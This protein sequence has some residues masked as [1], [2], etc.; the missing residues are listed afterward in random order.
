MSCN[1]C[2]VCPD[3]EAAQ[4]NIPIGPSGPL[5][6][7]GPTGPDGAVGATGAQGIQGIQGLQGDPGPP[8]PSSGAAPLDLY[9][10][11]LSNYPARLLYMNLFS[12]PGLI[13]MFSITSANFSVGGEGLDLTGV[14]GLDMRGWCICDGSVYVRTDGTGNIISPNLEGKFIVGVDPGDVDFSLANTGGSKN[15]T[16]KD[17]TL[18]DS[19]IPDHAHTLTGV[20]IDDHRHDLDTLLLDPPVVNGN[21]IHIHGVRETEAIGCGGTGCKVALVD[22]TSTGAGGNYTLTN[23][24]SASSPGTL[25]GA[26]THGLAGKTDIQD[27]STTG[28]TGDTDG[29]GAG[30]QWDTT[31]AENTGGAAN[32]MPP[33]Y[34]LLY[35]MRY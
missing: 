21:G 22:V 24:H 9:T 1:N 12:S 25:R 18:I 20:S 5:G 30:S 19:N 29:Y 32:A 15:H 6:P 11:L 14:G 27:P 10:E 28:I 35:I 4:I 3:C 13:N 16:H 26:H 23:E 34:S 33:Y 8:G 2:G 31:T 17:N 7:M